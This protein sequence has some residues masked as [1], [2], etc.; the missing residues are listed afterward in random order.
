[1]ITWLTRNV[2]VRH[3]DLFF[4]V[5]VDAVDAL[6]L[7][8]REMQHRFAHGLAGDG[9]GIDA[10]SADNFALLDYRDAAAALRSLNRRALPRGAGAD[11]DEVVI[12]AS[13][14]LE[15]TYS[16]QRR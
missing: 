10:G 2:E 11:D 9:A 7:K 8:A 3:V 16:P 1:M 6:I 15:V 5:I 13:F 12:H 4:D 14:V